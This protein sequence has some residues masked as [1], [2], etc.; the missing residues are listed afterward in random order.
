MKKIVFAVVL[1]AMG[2]NYASACVFEPDFNKCMA[3]CTQGYS[4]LYP[5]CALGSS[6]PAGQNK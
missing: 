6:A 4:F 1:L 2:A 5:G 3:A